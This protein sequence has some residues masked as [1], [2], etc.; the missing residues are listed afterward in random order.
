MAARTVVA[1]VPSIRV[2][3]GTKRRR[4]LTIALLAVLVVSMAVLRSEHAT[5]SQA[6]SVG[7]LSVFVGYAEDKEINTPDPASF[8]VPWAGAANTVF[9]G[10]TVPGQ[11]AC[12]S[13]T[14]CYD[15]GAIRLDNP[16]SSA[17]TV[18]SVSVDDHSS[19]VGGKVFNNLWG[20]F[21][22]FAGQSI[23]LTE[24]P[25]ANNATYDNF[26]TSSYPNN[27]CTP[28]TVPPTV[29]ITVKGA[30]TTLADSTHVLDMAVSTPA[31]GRHS[32]TSRSSGGRSARRARMQP[33]FL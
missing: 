16:S 13:L 6:P 23:I 21:T 31:R 10:G 12:G 2:R 26:D 19:V 17:I 24:N 33:L 1:A 5:A 3:V 11:A 7:G 27:N 20:S 8:P 32:V 14:V 15:A 29:A 4:L 22:V 9:L 30:A 28:V 25:P 18:D